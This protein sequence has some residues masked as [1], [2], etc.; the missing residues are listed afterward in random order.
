M[1]FNSGRLLT[2]PSPGSLHGVRILLVD[3]SSFIRRLFTVV[4]QELG[5]LVTSAADGPQAVRIVASERPFD[6]LIIEGLLR[7]GT[8]L[9]DDLC[10][11]SPGGPKPIVILYTGSVRQYQLRHGRIPR[12]VDAFVVKDAT[13]EGLAEK[14]RELLDDRA[15]V[16]A[17]RPASCEIQGS[18]V[19][20]SAR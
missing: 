6:V 14:V 12:C 17:G 18:G 11:I 2:V 10:S 20:P 13:G 1:F 3:E 5:A 19:L 9:C 4:F 8:E 7:E 15:K 16:Q